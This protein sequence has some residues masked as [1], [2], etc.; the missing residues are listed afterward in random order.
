MTRI[1]IAPTSGRTG[2]LPLTRARCQRAIS[3]RTRSAR[4]C[5]LA[6]VG[7][8]RCPNR[9]SISLRTAVRISRSAVRSS[10][11]TL[12]LPEPE[13]LSAQR[14]PDD[15]SLF[16]D[17]PQL[18]SGRELNQRHSGVWATAS[19][20]PTTVVVE[21]PQQVGAAPGG[22]RATAQRT[23]AASDQASSAGRT[24][25]GAGLRQPASRHSDQTARPRSEEHTSE[26]QSQFHIVCRLLLE[27]KISC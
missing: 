22:R 6:A 18:G 25:R 15:H 24:Q 1:S 27:K 3:T 2:R 13:Y 4:R 23:A 20:P 21:A 9:L 11:I 17:G 10:G 8:S 14:A 19:A 5:S 7:P 12:W 16:H 26:L